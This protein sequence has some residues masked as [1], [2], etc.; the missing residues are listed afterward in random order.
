M[1]YLKVLDEIAEQVQACLEGA[2][3]G[4]RVI[5]S[6]SVSVTRPQPRVPAPSG[7]GELAVTPIEP[8]FASYY[9]EDNRSASLA[10][11]WVVEED[12]PDDEGDSGD[13]GEAD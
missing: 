11:S 1:Y 4:D 8:M 9:P 13:E 7:V 6:C 2:D 10:R 3:L 12:D 5:V